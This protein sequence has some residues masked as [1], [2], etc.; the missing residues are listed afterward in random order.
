MFTSFNAKNF[1]QRLIGT[2][3]GWPISMLIEQLHIK[4]NIRSFRNNEDSTKAEI[5]G[6]SDALNSPHGSLIS[7][8]GQGIHL[9]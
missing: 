4:K 3:F 1:C 7:D 8:G 9:A 5:I 2:V 6:T